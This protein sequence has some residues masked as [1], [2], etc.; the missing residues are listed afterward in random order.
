MVVII[1]AVRGLP[2]HVVRW[3]SRITMVTRVVLRGLMHSGVHGRGHTSVHVHIVR[4]MHVPIRVRGL[5]LSLGLVIIVLVT[6]L[7]I[8]LCLSASLS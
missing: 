5:L 2:I 8:P 1:V 6:I 7:L 4:R 3:V